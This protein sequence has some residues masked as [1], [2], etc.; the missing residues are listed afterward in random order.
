MRWYSNSCDFES[1]PYV[2]EAFKQRKWAFVSDYIRFYALYK[3]GGIYLDSDVVVKKRLDS[4]L[5]A[6]FFVERRLFI[7]K[8]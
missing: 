1:A 2:R 3:Y 6:D 5:D 7:M 4:L 8:M